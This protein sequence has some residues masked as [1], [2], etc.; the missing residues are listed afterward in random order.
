MS[1]HLKATIEDLTQL[2]SK[3]GGGRLID[4]VNMVC[5][6]NGNCV[7]YPTEYI[8]ETW[9]LIKGNVPLSQ[10][11]LEVLEANYEKAIRTNQK[12]KE[13]IEM[14]LKTCYDNPDISYCIKETLKEHLTL[15]IWQGKLSNGHWANPNKKFKHE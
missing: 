14:V 15:E 4:K 13:I 9:E 6:F 12:Y 10:E 8:E 1:V 2:A 7:A 5:F 11:D 3:G